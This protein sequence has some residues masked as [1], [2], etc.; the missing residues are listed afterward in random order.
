MFT[1]KI[2]N[3]IAEDGINILIDKRII[4]ARLDAEILMAKTL[5]KDRK[6]I[7]LNNKEDLDKRGPT[8]L[9]YAGRKK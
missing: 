1:Y 5:K 3:N 2:F 4:T 9:K 7:I 8:K 6:Y